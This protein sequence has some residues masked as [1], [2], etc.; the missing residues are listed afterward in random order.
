MN[1]D[2]YEKSSEE[3]KLQEAVRVL[4]LKTEAVE[5]FTAEIVQSLE[6][7]ESRMKLSPENKE[8]GRY[9]AG[10]R[11]ALARWR[12]IPWNEVSEDDVE[13]WVRE[14]EELGVVNGRGSGYEKNISEQR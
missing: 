13:S 11:L 14:A 12:D 1:K 3:L 6:A 2:P 10:L 9:K 7:L 4:Q 8:I 5:Y